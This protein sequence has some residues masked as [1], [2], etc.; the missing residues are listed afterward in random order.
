VS[1]DVRGKPLG[2]GDKKLITRSMPDTIV[3]DFEAIEIEK[4]KGYAPTIRTA[5]DCLETIDAQP[6][7]G[8]TSERVVES[9]VL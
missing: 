3:D 2:D 9:K 5:Q 7:V 6:T 4:Q 8:E 1:S